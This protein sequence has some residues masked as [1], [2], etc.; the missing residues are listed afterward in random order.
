MQR[1]VARLLGLAEPPKPADAADALALALHHLSMAPYRAATG[2]ALA[3]QHGGAASFE[4]RLESR[5]AS[6]L[7]G[8]SNAIGKARIA[9]HLGNG[10]A[11][12]GLA[13]NGLA[14]KESAEKKATR[15]AP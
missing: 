11:L 1:M 5:I 7:G 9:T 3:T 4:S 14:L 2:A 8:S 15:S 13:L 10:L 6:S 12:N